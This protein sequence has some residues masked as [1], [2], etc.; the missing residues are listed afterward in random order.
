MKNIIK[1]LGT[2][3][4]LAAPYLLLAQNGT[5]TINGNVGQLSA[6]AKA[7]LL[8]SNAT[9][10]Q[11]DSTLINNGSFSFTGVIT[12]PES[13]LLII[14]KKGTGA[15]TM[16][17]NY[18]TFYLEPATITVTCPDYS[19]IN[20][21]VDGGPTN[22]D[23]N[24]LKMALTI[25][26]GKIDLLNKEYQ[27]APEEKRKSK[28]FNDIIEKRRDSVET[29][30]KAV[31]R[32]FIIANPNSLVSL[33][34]LKSFAGSVPDVAEVE[35][36]FNSLS[37]SLRSTKLGTDYATD[38]EKM[39][40]TTIGTTAPDFAQPDTAGKLISLHDF[41]GKYVLVDFWAS[42]CGPCRAENPN[43]VKA[44]NKYK[45]KGFT[46]LGVSLDKQ[47]SR[48]AWL[49]AIKADG[50]VWT[51]VSDLKGWNNEAAGLYAVKSIPQNFL[52]APNGVVIGKN[53]RG[54]ELDKKLTELFN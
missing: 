14:N 34:A 16:P 29:E 40:K 38:I 22:A 53:L 7:Y 1:F 30:R 28:E 41:K 37:E 50:L 4:M 9:G 21:K 15:S 35:P 3:Y 32:A 5:Y 52:I 47:L 27:A 20:A 11:T 42:W 31:Y 2:A 45:D 33:F 26:R 44:Y 12:N 49:K 51:Q 48:L 43:V 13:A 18:I 54:E 39:K 17:I 6:P 46:V 23:N 19:L 10:R 8:Y 25:V 24:R 36:V